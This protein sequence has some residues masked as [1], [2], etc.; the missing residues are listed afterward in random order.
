MQNRLR[1]KTVCVC[2]YIVRPQASVSIDTLSNCSVL[3][4][5]DAALGWR[6]GDRLV[7]SS[8]DYSMYQAEEFSVLPCATCTANQVKVEG[9]YVV[10][11]ALANSSNY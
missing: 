5:A 8:T 7:V 11:K 10:F 3:F 4:L 2:V 1:N 6:T 9:Q